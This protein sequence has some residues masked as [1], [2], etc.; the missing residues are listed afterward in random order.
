[1]NVLFHGTESK[2]SALAAESV[3]KQDP[4]AYWNFH[5]ELFNA[6]PAN[7]DDPWITPEK[8][9]EIAKTYTPSINTTQLEEDLKKQTEQE[10]VNRDEKL[11][12]DYSVE[13]TPSIVVN[14]TMLSD[15]Y[16]YEQIKSLIEKALK[17]KK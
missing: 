14:G 3:Y 12:Q 2:L 1:M 17:E 6:Q 11:T 10:E 13:Q 15:P 9:L 8:L 16:D 5:K 4:Q 7:H